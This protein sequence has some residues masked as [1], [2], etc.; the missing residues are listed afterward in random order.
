MHR[1]LQAKFPEICSINKRIDIFF[2]PDDFLYVLIEIFRQERVVTNVPWRKAAYKTQQ[3][4]KSW[5]FNSNSC[6][7]YSGKTKC[8]RQTE[9]FNPLQFQQLKYIQPEMF[10][11]GLKLSVRWNFLPPVILKVFFRQAVPVVESL[12]AIK[13]SIVNANDCN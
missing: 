13:I 11:A 5:G 8:D 4:C 3:I 6:M 7:A 9:F 1:V 2:A 12:S 10:I